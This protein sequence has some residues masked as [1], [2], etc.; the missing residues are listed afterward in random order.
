MNMAGWPA[1]WQENWKE[2]RGC[3]KIQTG[4][5]NGTPRLRKLET[6]TLCT[7]W[8]VFA[9]KKYVTIHSIFLNGVLQCENC[10]EPECCSNMQR[11][12]ILHI[13][14]KHFSGFY[15]LR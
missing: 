7:G 14:R 3:L 5:R 8:L 10:P 6:W 11:K 15:R 13:H 9:K 12:I 4:Q 2:D 1:I